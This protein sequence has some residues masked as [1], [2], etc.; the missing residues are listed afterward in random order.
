MREP[1]NDSLNRKL[2]EA[3]F[4]GA[5]ND[6][7]K[8]HLASQGYSG[9]VSDMLAKVGGIRNYAETF[10]ED[11]ALDPGLYQG[12]GTLDFWDSAR[13][14]CEGSVYLDGIQSTNLTTATCGPSLR[15]EG[16]TSGKD[17]RIKFK[18]TQDTGGGYSMF[19]FDTSMGLYS[20][21]FGTEYGTDEVE[22][23][24][25]LTA[26]STVMY[27]GALHIGHQAG[28]FIRMYEISVVEAP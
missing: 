21:T 8:A 19:R 23:D 6:K 15:L 2:R 24:V 22:W 5:L 3:G 17:Y 11:P 4:I 27:L 16:L 25:T 13:S 12:A 26:G 28:G 9:T 10:T 14:G 18:S 7:I 1:F 20:G